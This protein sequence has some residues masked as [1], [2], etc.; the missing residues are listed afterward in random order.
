MGTEKRS[1][2]CSYLVTS[3]TRG[4]RLHCKSGKPSEVRLSIEKKS[5]THFFQKDAG[6][7]RDLG[8]RS[9]NYHG[10]FQVT[11]HDV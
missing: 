6:R 5:G 10:T 2:E 11:V 4:R 3:P 1:V 7:R 9:H 8:I